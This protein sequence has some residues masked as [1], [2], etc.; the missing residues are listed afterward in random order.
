MTMDRNGQLTFSDDPNLLGVNEA[1]QMI[2]EGRFSDAVS[3][4]DTLLSSNPDYPGLSDTYR[5]AKFWDNRAS[6]LKKLNRGKQ[7]ADFLMTQWELFKTYAGEK[8]LIHTPSYKAA[9]RYIFFTASENY[10]IAFQDQE[11]TTDNF[12]LLLNLGVCFLNLGEYK[13]TVETL[14]YARSSY[15]SNARLVSLLAEA[16]FN[17]NEIPKSLLYFR[18]AFFL[19]PSEIDLTLLKSKPIIDLTTRVQEGRP[20]CRDIREWIPIYGFL[21]DVFYV[22][23]NLN[24]AQLEGIKREIYTLEK[25]FQTMSREK[26]EDTNIVPRLVNKYLWMLDY[27]E[28][29]NYD[30]ESIT[31]IR[32]RLLQIDRRL[33]EEHFKKDKK[34]Q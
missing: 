29:Q 6:E 30:F 24:S 31:E 27:F 15:R 19:N 21:D 23:R 8:N 11:S 25:N 33:F 26:V 17:L 12:D 1:Y 4:T 2:E 3:K 34:K 10:K 7:T 5:T 20:G 18:E 32:S 9:M 14:E 13:H 28:F 16:Y 22:K